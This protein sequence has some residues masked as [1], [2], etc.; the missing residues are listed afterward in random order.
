MGWG[1]GD[2][3]VSR[4]ESPWQWWGQ[5]EQFTE[6]RLTIKYTKS[7]VWVKGFAKTN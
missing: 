4:T 3:L 2:C 5:P 6:K 1:E 7:A